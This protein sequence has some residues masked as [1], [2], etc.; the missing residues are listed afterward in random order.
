MNKV[1]ELYAFDDEKLSDPVKKFRTTAAPHQARALVF[2]L[3]T[4]PEGTSPRKHAKLF[5][6][7]LKTITGSVVLKTGHGFVASATPAALTVLAQLPAVAKVADAPDLHKKVTRDLT[8]AGKKG[9]APGSRKTAK[10]APK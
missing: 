7:T 5:A 9:K 1:S 2:G 8:W 10:P 3:A 6:A 4:P